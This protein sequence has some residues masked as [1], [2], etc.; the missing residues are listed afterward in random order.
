MGVA[1]M[2]KRTATATQVQ[3]IHQPHKSALI[4]NTMATNLAPELFEHIAVG[5]LS[6]NA[7]A[8]ATSRF[9]RGR[10]GASA[11]T[12]S[13]ATRPEVIVPVLVGALRAIDSPVALFPAGVAGAVDFDVLFA[14]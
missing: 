13:P 12:A 1:A 5:L 4:L 8:G 10:G 9:T 3:H 11:C 14:P 7:N 2:N 6:T